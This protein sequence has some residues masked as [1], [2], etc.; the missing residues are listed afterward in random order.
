MKSSA[1]TIGPALLSS[2]AI[3]NFQ[4]RPNA[5]VCD[6]KLKSGSTKEHC[7]GK[8]R[9]QQARFAANPTRRTRSFIPY[10]LRRLLAAE[11]LQIRWSR[12]L[13]S[14]AQHARRAKNDQ[15]RARNSLT[16]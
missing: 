5:P 14:H 6:S 10:T 12:Q 16:F 1:I 4:T 13:G 3:R 15:M 8:Q 11:L 2:D 7:G 9:M